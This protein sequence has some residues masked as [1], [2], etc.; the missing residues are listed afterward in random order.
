MIHFIVERTFA[1]PPSDEDLAEAARRQHNCLDIYGV[2][3]KR[4]VMSEDRRRGICEYDALDAE[5]VR[6][7]QY[8]S[9][10]PFDR[11]WI[12]HVVE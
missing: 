8:E 4:S 5:S 12:G 2:T 9:Q 7:V 10:S 11:V 6:K 3:W 1:I